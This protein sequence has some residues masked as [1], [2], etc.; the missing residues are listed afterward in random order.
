M[1]PISTGMTA[2][3]IALP[4]RPG[5]KSMDELMLR[6]R[7]KLM[8]FWDL[9]YNHKEGMYWPA[10]AFMELPSAREYPDYYQVIAHPIDL[11]MIREKIENNKYESSV[12]LMQE[13]TVLFNNA[14]QYNEANSQIARDASMLLEM[15]I[16]AHAND[17]D[18][19]YESPLQLKQKFG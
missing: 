16:K 19:P 2:E 11:K 5:R 13:F 4:G 15:V 12:Q 8:S 9:I 1:R 18:A 7:Q 14:R 17:K 10:G 6:F 3:H